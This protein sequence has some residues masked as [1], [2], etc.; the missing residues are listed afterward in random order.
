MNQELE[1]LISLQSIDSKILDIESLAGD[2][3]QKVEKKEQAIKDMSDRLDAGSQRLDEIDKENRKL[4]SEIEDGEASLAKY[5]DQLFLVK[6]NKEYDALNN[7]IDHLKKT[8]SESEEK[9]ILLEEEKETLL[10]TK[11]SNKSDIDT[12][13]EILEKEKT[14]LDDALNESKA[15]LEELNINRKSI[16]NKIESSYLSQY[17][18][19]K[20][21]KGVGVAPLN[22]DCCGSCYSMLPPQMVVE[23]KSNNII[24][25]C[26]SCSVYSYWEKEEEV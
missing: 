10:K 13:N 3:P 7:E 16:M 21:V 5:K 1:N 6:S 18:T 15:E 17:N 25:S 8:I 4:K 14:R 20:E 2:L 22:G 9:Y 24:H 26:P 19:L 23:I 11:E 12:L